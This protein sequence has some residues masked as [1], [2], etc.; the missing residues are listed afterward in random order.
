MKVKVKKLIKQ[1]EAT[2]TDLCRGKAAAIVREVHNT[3]VPVVIIKNSKSYAAVISY[4][5]FLKV[6]EIL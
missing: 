2:A 4:E 3:N 5:Q 6:K 1:K